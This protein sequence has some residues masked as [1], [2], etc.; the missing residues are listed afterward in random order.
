MSWRVRSFGISLTSF[1]CGYSSATY[2]AVGWYWMAAAT[3][4]IF[5]VALTLL[6]FAILQP[7]MEQE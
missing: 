1:S 6:W 4:F 7:S 2:M 5:I 3:F